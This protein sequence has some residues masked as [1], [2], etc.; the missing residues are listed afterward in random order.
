MIRS[1][2]SQGPAGRFD[3]VLVDRHAPRV[4]GLEVPRWLTTYP[5]QGRVPV[6][7]LTSG[8]DPEGAARRVTAAGHLIKPLRQSRLREALS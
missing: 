4:D 5:P 1:V 8:R 7:L 6:I 3:V 2:P